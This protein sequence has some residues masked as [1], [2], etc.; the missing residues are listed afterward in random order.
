MKKYVFQFRERNEILVMTK[1]VLSNHKVQN[2]LLKGASLGLIEWKFGNHI[3][4]ITFE[5]LNFPI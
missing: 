1:R 4:K 2:R 5:K 3:I